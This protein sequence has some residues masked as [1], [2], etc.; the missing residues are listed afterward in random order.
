MSSSYISFRDIINY[1][2]IYRIS[3]EIHSFLH[4]VNFDP[5]KNLE[6]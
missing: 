5:N 4:L 1:L 2:E 6:I 3:G